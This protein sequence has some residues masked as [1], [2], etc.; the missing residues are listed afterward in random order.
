MFIFDTEEWSLRDKQDQVALREIG[1]M[2]DTERKSRYDQISDALDLNPDLKLIRLD[3]VLPLPPAE[4]P[5]WKGIQDV[6]E[7]DPEG[8]PS[9]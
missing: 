8:P 2:P 3:Q 6:I 1:I 5:T 7:P 9:Y 4:L